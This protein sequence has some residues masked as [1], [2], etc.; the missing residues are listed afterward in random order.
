MTRRPFSGSFQF[1]RV[2][3]PRPVGGV[4][5]VLR[6][7]LFVKLQ[8]GKNTIDLLA[9]V[10]TGA[11]FSILPTEVAEELGIDPAQLPGEGLPFTGVTAGGAGKVV[12]LTVRTPQDRGDV[13]LSMEIP[14]V[15]IIKGGLGQGKDVLLGRHP[16][17]HDFD[18]GFRMGY[19][20]DPEIGKWTMKE[21]QK[22]K[23]A[24]K[25]VRYEHML[26]PE[27]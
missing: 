12:N 14:F 25:Y 10:D 4:E 15:V 6:P 11:D 2:R 1:N 20:D 13:W 26:R 19:T 16:L 7:Y 27:E 5:T 18:F 8:H 17:F 3:L 23:S 9:L 22:R 21:I 24:S